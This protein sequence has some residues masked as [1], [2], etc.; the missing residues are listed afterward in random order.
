M[1]LKGSVENLF[2]EAIEIKEKKIKLYD[3]LKDKCDDEVGKEVFDILKDLEAKSLES[4]KKA[5]EEMKKG[6]DWV[7]LCSYIP[8]KAVLGEMIISKVVKSA[9]GK[10]SCSK[11]FEPFDV[12]ISMEDQAIA[13]FK[14]F[15]DMA[16]SEEEKR[17][18]GYHLEEEREHR[19]LLED[20]RYYYRDP[21]GWFM[22]KGKA[23][24]DGA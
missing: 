1:S 16:E 19:K 22:E 7:G 10:T 18:L 20:L 21:Q 13:L 4:L 14:R 23:V 17:F 2:C 12:A 5:Y 15:F 24:L 6:K 9:K 8:E 3:D 11:S